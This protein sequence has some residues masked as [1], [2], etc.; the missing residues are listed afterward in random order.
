MKWDIDKALKALEGEGFPG[1]VI[2]RVLLSG[3]DIIQR[4]NIPK[5]TEKELE[6]GVKAWSLGLGRAQSP[7]FFVF[8]RSIRSAYLQARKIIK[9]MNPKAREA[10]GIK[11][12]K[13]NANSF[14]SARRK[15]K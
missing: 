12:P 8:G 3:G 11:A 4:S 6:F 5:P 1:T 14:A 13:K 2:C 7:K 10:Y 15:H 9:K